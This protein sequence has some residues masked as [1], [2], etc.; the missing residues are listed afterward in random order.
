MA[1]KR[2]YYEILG[3]SRSADGEQ[4]KR[5]Y[6]K[7]AMKYHP[8]RN[9]GDEEAEVKFKE[10]AEAYEVLTDPS[11]RERYDRYG[12]EGLRGTS[13]HDFSHMD[14]GD[15]FS[16]FEDI[17]GGFGGFG[18]AGRGRRGQ[19]A[20]RGY[21]LETQVEITL[22]EVLHGCEKEIDFTREDLCENCNGTGGKPGS[23]PIV[24]A[25]CGGAGKV[26][27]SGFGGMFRMVTSCPSCQGQGRYYGEKCGSCHG[28]GR[29]PRHRVL[30]VRVPAGVRE[31]QAVRVAGE[32][33]PGPA[34]NGSEG[35]R[36]DLHVV[37]TIKEHKLFE[38]DG[39]HL[40][41]RMPI[42]FTQAALGATIETPTLEDQ[43]QIT[44][45]P[46]SQHGDMIRLEGRGLP[47]L[48]SGQR[49]DMIVL[50]MIEI[51][52]KL[53]AKQKE[54]LREFAETE[55]RSVMPHSNG[56]WERIK[57]YLS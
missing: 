48:R 53:S 23:E 55:D 50:Q 28:K 9:P 40:I 7:L 42:S 56:F 8:D 3:V 14:A 43:E 12:H 1:T 19:R 51:P 35:P 44:I 11:K 47:N 32:G 37:V 36:G 54:L 49:G 6:R 27:Q 2:D 25:T 38:R 18:G 26:Q 52:K 15:I 29:K 34:G 4:I 46:G 45:R 10:A 30:T 39:D 17:F 20:Q 33:E 22:E 41:L 31:G 57:E 21:D 16:M 24:C 5:A 13:G